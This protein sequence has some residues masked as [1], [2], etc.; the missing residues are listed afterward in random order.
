MTEARLIADSGAAAADEEFFRSTQFYAAEGVSHS[1][2]VEDLRIPV[3]VS[4]V[5]GTDLRDAASPYGYPGG[6]GGD[7]TALPASSVDWG[8]TGLVS[9]FVRDRAG[10][11]SLADG[12]LRSTLHL[13]DP[14]L[15]EALSATHRRHIRRNARLGYASTRSPGPESG[16]DARA[17]F[18]ALYRQTMSRR[19]AG[20]RYLFSDEYLETIL[21]SPA[22]WLFVTTTGDGAP[23][24]AAIA[25]RSDGVLHYY[26]GGSAD[27]LLSHSPLKSTIA[28][29]IEL[30][31]EEGLPLNLGGGVV[32]G[33][34]LERFKRGFANSTAPFRTH[35]VVCDPAAYERLSGG[36]QSGGFFPAYRAP[37][38]EAR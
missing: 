17:A 9:L 22:A 34:S 5:P 20:A 24:A 2:V 6:S 10:T 27:E 33:D 21:R 31:A 36:R 16:P 11:P 12:T 37:N 4:P 23:A 25:G 15:P 28:A 32:P 35:E 30:A 8:R 1:L 26:L 19:G 13:V 38:P 3:I 18:S 7:H 29:M 14:R